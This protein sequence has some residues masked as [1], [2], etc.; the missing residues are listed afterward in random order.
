M[1]LAPDPLPNDVAALQAIIAKQAKELDKREAALE[2]AKA[3]LSD[4]KTKLKARDLIID[5][6]IGHLAML[7]GNEND[8]E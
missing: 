7:A 4:A 2:E 3:A 8:W 5:V 1:I 6:G